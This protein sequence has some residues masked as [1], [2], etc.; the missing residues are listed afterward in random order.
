MPHFRSFFRAYLLGKR[1]PYAIVM[2]CWLEMGDLL[3]Y[4][5]DK[6]GFKGM[7]AQKQATWNPELD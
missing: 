6:E 7:D 3:S 4:K 5:N 2:G 1:T